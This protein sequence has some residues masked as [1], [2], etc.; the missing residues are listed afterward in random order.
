MES[1]KNW[2]RGSIQEHNCDVTLWKNVFFKLN[3]AWLQFFFN[4]HVDLTF[5]LLCYLV[6][7]YQIVIWNFQAKQARWLCLQWGSTNSN[8]GACTSSPSGEILRI[9]RACLLACL[10]QMFNKMEL[11]ILL[12]L[13]YIGTPSLVYNIFSHLDSRLLV[14]SL[15]FFYFF[16][17]YCK[18]Q[19]LKCINHFS[20]D[21]NCL[22]SLQR[23]DVITDT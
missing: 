6:K 23:A 8:N 15:D 13:R 20:M 11:P 14:Q 3:R 2:F 1:Q 22:E 21:P 9:A 19:I 10:F 5:D 17:F 18:V 7:S 12:K 16:I 4:F